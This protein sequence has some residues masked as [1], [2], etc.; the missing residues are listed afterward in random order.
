MQYQP[1]PQGLLL[2]DFQDGGSSVE[3][4]TT[5]RHLENRRG[6][7]PGDEVGAVQ[8]SAHPKKTKKIEIRC[9]DL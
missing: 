5:I 8:Y 4:S 2:D 6:E 1:R 9:I 3:A 7:G